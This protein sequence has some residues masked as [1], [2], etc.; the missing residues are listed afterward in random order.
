[1]SVR[2]D[3]GNPYASEATIARLANDAYNANPDPIPYESPRYRRAAD[4]DNNG[5]VAGRNELFPLYEAAARDFTQPLFVF[6]P[7]RM[8]RFGVEVVF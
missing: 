3:T 6:G 4:L 1:M 2:R 5:L 7:P 8:V